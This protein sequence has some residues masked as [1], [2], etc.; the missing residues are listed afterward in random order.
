MTALIGGF[1]RALSAAVPVTSELKQGKPM[2]ELHKNYGL[3][4]H[5]IRRRVWFLILI[6]DLIRSIYD[7]KK[8]NMIYLSQQN[9]KLA[10]S[11]GVKS[12][13]PLI[14]HLQMFLISCNVPG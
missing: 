14:G 13:N 11:V 12:S 10:L 2:Y 5:G 3:V 8:Q 4:T 9:L 6:P 7:F 1:L